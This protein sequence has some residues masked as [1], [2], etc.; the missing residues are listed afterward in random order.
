MSRR[1]GYCEEL[2]I[3]KEYAPQMISDPVAIKS[4]IKAITEADPN[5]ALSKAN[6]GYVMKSLAAQLRGKADMSVVN[7]V[8]NDLLV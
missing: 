2:A 8:V 5:L 3:V 4:M 7:K 1:L 6:R